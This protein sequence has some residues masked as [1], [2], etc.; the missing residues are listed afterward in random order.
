[1]TIE[2]RFWSYVAKSGDCWEWVGT[3]RPEGYGLFWNGERQVRAHRFAWEL[4]NGPIPAGLSLCHS[5]DNPP[6]VRPDHLFVGTQRQ[7]LEDM[8]RKGR[9]RS[10]PPVREQNGSANAMAKLTEEQVAHIKGMAA[11]GHYHDDIAA[12]FGVTRANVSYVTRKTWRHV[13]PVPYPPAV[14]DRPVGRSAPRRRAERG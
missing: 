1:M 8:T 7:N 11:A 3:R 12:R 5:C 14:R 13:E 6:C 10:R 9:R 4:V 2:D